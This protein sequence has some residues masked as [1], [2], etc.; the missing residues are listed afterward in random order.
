MDSA[1]S[2]SVSSPVPN[3]T[4]AV[5]TPVVLVWI[6]MLAH[7]PSIDQAVSKPLIPPFRLEYVALYLSRM[8]F[9]ACYHSARF[10]GVLET[11]YKIP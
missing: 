7:S 3:K 4:V 5:I 6:Q 11:L 10:W 2:L 1:S 9:S 8:V